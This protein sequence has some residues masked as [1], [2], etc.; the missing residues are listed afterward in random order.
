MAP[1]PP[2]YPVPPAE[3]GRANPLATRIPELA[4]DGVDWRWRRRESRGV[5]GGGVRGARIRTS[6]RV[7]VAMAFAVFDRLM[8]SM[9]FFNATRFAALA[10]L[11]RG[12]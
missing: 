12:Y 8:L 7:Y 2:S 10:A 11:G 9:F 3:V 4:K 1:I 6:P 5:V